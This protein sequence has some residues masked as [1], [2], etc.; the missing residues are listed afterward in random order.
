M[1]GFTQ[2]MQALH[3]FVLY[4]ITPTSPASARYTQS[5]AHRLNLSLKPLCQSVRR[6]QNAVGLSIFSKL[7]QL[8]L[9]VPIYE[10]Y[11]NAASKK[12]CRPIFI[13]AYC[14][15]TSCITK[16]SAVDLLNKIAFRSLS[17]WHCNSVKH[18]KTYSRGTRPFSTTSNFVDITLWDEY[19]GIVGC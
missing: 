5:Q 18:F 10:M 1:Q 8:H 4:C 15:W 6:K 9:N 16:Y 14:N 11:F 13:Q 12:I 7:I 19:V 3:M 17:L 2:T